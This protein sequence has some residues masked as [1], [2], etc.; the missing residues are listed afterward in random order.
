MTV[1]ELA[2][3]SAPLPAGTGPS[4]RTRAG[5]GR[6][7][8][9]LVVLTVFGAVIRLV[10]AHQSL[11]GDEL[12][13]YWIVAAH[14][15]H[16]VLSLL[17]GTAS[18]HHAEISPP[19]SFVASWFTIQLGHSA[20]LLRLPSLIAGT[21]SI[22]LVYLLGR[23]TFGAR[24]A[25]VAAVLTTLSPF[26][27][28][29]STEA[30]AY[31]LMMAF[32][33]GSTLSLLSA[34]DTGR[35]R[36]W[37]SYAVCSC[38]AFY[39][40]YTCFFVLATQL[41]WAWLSHPALRRPL[42]AAN[43]GAAVGVVP[44]L[45]G[46]HNDLTSP[47]VKILSALS[48]FTWHDVRVAIGHWALGYPYANS[49]SLGGLPGPLALVALGLCVLLAAGAIARRRGGGSG[50]DPHPDHRL[51]L[52]VA[53]AVA[54]AVG[55]ALASAVST[56][57]FGVRNLAAS[58]PALGLCFAALLVAAGPRVRLVTVG[59]AVL[60]F[61]I[62]AVDLLLPANRRPDYAAAATLIEHGSP[63]VSVVI[64]ETGEIS[65]GPL[66]PLDVALSHPV[67][68]VRAGAPA[69][70][71]HPYSFTDPLVGI[72][73]ATREAVAIANGGPIAVVSTL[74]PPGD[75]T[76]LQQR[77]TPRTA[78]I[79]APYRLIATHT[80]AGIARVQVKVYARSAG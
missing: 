56:H 34:I 80:Y 66:T 79:P 45:P 57:V 19:L 28:Y 31:G 62:A 38:A 59:L 33:I 51:G 76:A 55:E 11:F 77:T 10:V 75:I 8:V 14:G 69:E 64:D 12:S 21:L 46:L 22:P 52:L 39:S 65:P 78:P 15:L 35:R 72:D 40:H 47:T 5:L 71:D 48:P 49:I 63:H 18:F 53:L 27:V 4:Q 74:S 37:V 9:A 60:A 58:W 24:A 67:A 16:G 70:R 25:W 30:R 36:W 68:T 17:W 2:E 13:T 41:V 54:T 44:W 61:A 23:R 42:L 73:A 50:L 43:F 32:T 1:P 29:Y 26:M 7:P 6:V 3:R 20:I